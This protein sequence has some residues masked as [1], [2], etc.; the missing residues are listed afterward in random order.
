MALGKQAR[1]QNTIF[2]SAS[3]PSLVNSVGLENLLVSLEDQFTSLQNETIST[4]FMQNFS[5]TKWL[6]TLKQMRDAWYS[7]LFSRE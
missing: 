7:Q 6:I 5:Q 3:F 2:E 4:F 1:N